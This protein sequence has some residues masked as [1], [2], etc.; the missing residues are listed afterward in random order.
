MIN[1]FPELLSLSLLAPTLLRL[2][3]SVYIINLGISKIK[4][5]NSA[6]GSFFESLGFKPSNLYIKSLAYIELIVGIMLFVGFL[7]QIAALVVAIIMFVSLIVAIRHPE[8][9]LKGISTYALLFIIAISLV[10]TGA[11]LI[12][13]DLPL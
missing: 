6:L 3:L 7:T 5:D 8:T 1:P 11:G 9:K 12:A 4:K 13:I 10:L 2:A